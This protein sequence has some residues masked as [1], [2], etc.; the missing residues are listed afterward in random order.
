M[1]TVSALVQTATVAPASAAPTWE[2]LPVPSTSWDRSIDDLAV[3]SAND[4]IAVGDREEQSWL[5]EW[6]ALVWRFDGTQ[7][8]E[9]PAPPDAG[10]L[11]SVAAASANDVWALSGDMYT[12]DRVYGSYVHRWNGTAWGTTTIPNHPGGGRLVARDIAVAGG[13]VWVAGSYETKPPQWPNNYRAPAILRWTGSGWSY[14]DV[15]APAGDTILTEVHVV[16]ATDVWA[17]GVENTAGGPR[18]YVVR[19]NGV[20][21]SQATTPATVPGTGVYAGIARANGEVWAGGAYTPTSDRD[22]EDT[23]AM[24]STGGAYTVTPTPRATSRRSYITNFGERGSELWAGGEGDTPLLRW[25]GTAW[26]VGPA[27]ALGYLSVTG[28]MAAP[29]NT[30]FAIGT[31]A[32]GTSTSSGPFIARL[33]G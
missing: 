9:H 21:W 24:R 19:W 23:F 13:T 1:L 14:L 25:T 27:P 33:T 22:P 15:P 2:V 31:G 6:R 28:L 32:R 12:P 10:S 4:A 29:N 11:Y 18:P 20:R 16:S 30:M 7:W 26:Q 5:V 17:T 8:R 3:I